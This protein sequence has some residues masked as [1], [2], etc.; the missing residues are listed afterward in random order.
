MIK[1]I[2]RISSL[3]NNK[4]QKQVLRLL[5]KI[6]FMAIIDTI[7]VASI[8][9]FF[10]VLTKPE[11]IK[12]NEYLNYLFINLKFTNE[13]NFLI[14]LGI[15]LLVILI[16]SMSYKSITVYFQ[17]KVE[18]LIEFSVCERLLKKY[19]MQPYTWFLN[20]NTSELGNNLITEVNHV[21]RGVLAPSISI[22]AQGLLAILMIIV[23]F[24]TDTTIALIALSTLSISYGLL[25]LS[26]RGYVY[27]LGIT[28]L[29]S[30]QIKHKMINEVFYGIKDVKVN[31]LEGFY[32]NLFS[33]AAE[34]YA[35][36]NAK[37]QILMQL[38]R[39][40][41]ESIFF[42]GIIFVSLVYVQDPENLFEILPSLAVIAFAGY[43]LLPALQLIYAN[44]IALTSVIPSLDLIYHEIDNLSKIKKS[45]IE[46][47]NIEI[48]KEITIQNLSYT[49]PFSKTK[50]IKRINMKILAK[51]TVGI[52]GKSGSG[53]T[54]IIDLILG[55]LKPSEGK[56]YVDNFLIDENN[57][58]SWQ[59]NIG[60][61]PQQTFLIDDT[62]SSNIAFGIKKEKIDFN[63]VEKVSKIAN[64]DSFILKEL[65]KGY[66]TIIGERGIRL[67]G[68]QRQR[69]GIARALYSNPNLLILDEATN[70]LDKNTEKVILNALKKLKN[71]ITIIIISH[72]LSTLRD[73]D[74]I[75]VMDQGIVK[76][77]SSYERLIQ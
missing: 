51:Q 59:S 28:R 47:R 19:L 35:L 39:F 21:V 26:L 25:Y 58:E 77:M 70:A 14:F 2:F 3:L 60:Y 23:I 10:T 41:I 63:Q 24:Y 56:I 8:F 11:I 37:T 20:K 71:K 33:N 15:L 5:V 57:I 4:E 38:P 17:L 13:S 68:G 67:S 16:S 22:I 76:S 69:I 52:I 9:P 42:G 7:G 62:I 30:S 43:K 34:K 29:D 1:K 45:K 50:V 66:S 73:T 49:Y 64:L 75:F 18:Q 48:E 74:K 44:F 53:K 55:L 40:L 72:H 12:T 46:N 61:V 36:S 32:H 31:R 65:D 54:T 6:I 27:N